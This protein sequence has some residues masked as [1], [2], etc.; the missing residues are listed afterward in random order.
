[1]K[2]DR[3]ERRRRRKRKIKQRINLATA[4]NQFFGIKPDLGEPGYF[5]NNNEMNKWGSAGRRKKT[6]I[7]NGHASYRHKGDYGKA[8]EYSPHDLRQV[9]DMEQQIKEANKEDNTDEADND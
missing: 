1:M 9:Q 8:I 5:S 7:K 6:K 4:I 2:L 3:S